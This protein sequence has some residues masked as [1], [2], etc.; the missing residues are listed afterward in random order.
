MTP[1]SHPHL[2]TT[3]ARRLPLLA[4]LI[5]LVA[6]LA[7]GC[8]ASTDGAAAAEGGQ[9][10]R[11]GTAWME[12]S[13]EPPVLNWYLASGGMSI[14]KVLTAPL[15]STWVRLDDRGAWQP[16]LATTV[17]TLDNGGVTQFPEGGMAIS[18][19][20]DPRAVW[21]DG[22]PITCDDLAFTWHTLMDDRWA[23]GSRVGWELVDDVECATPKHVRMMLR[24]AHAPYLANLLNTEPLPAHVL[25]G[26]DFDEVW[27][28]R[29]TVSS[30]PF[31]F[32]RWA[33]GDRLI[34]RRNPRWWNAG[35]EGKPYLDRLVVR[36]VPD[37]NTM[38]LDLR[39]EDADLVGLPPDTNLPAELASI[40]NAQYD[41]RPGAGWENLTF[42]TARFPLDDPRVRRA[43]AFAIDRD[44]L[45]D[46]V[47]ARQ[48]PRL[49]STLLPYQEPYVSPSFSRYHLD[50][51]EVAHRM[52]EAGWE[53][54]GQRDRW[55]D[56][57]GRS[58]KLLLTTTTGSPIRLKTVQIIADQ[59]DVAGFDSEI[60]LLKPEVF[61]AQVVSHG[62]YDLA[63][64]GFTQ[65]VDP[66]QTKLF[67]CSQIA[68]G[69]TW[70]GKNNFKYC[71][72]D[73]DALLAAS[74]RTLDPQRRAEL[75]HELAE[76]L[77]TD[78]PALPLYQ[79]PDTLAWNRRLHGVRPNAMG[80]HLWNVDEWWVSP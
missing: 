2:C 34:L 6:L 68:R 51:R 16:Q 14:T 76:R 45:V 56:P 20:I 13:Q 66:S 74:D 39:M 70:T 80:W 11:G 15:R 3:I 59:L 60:L 69:P 35:P 61:F 21:S 49:D 44:S 55:T 31:V 63:V 1:S 52:Q 33:R 54:H 71:R 37:A 72:R 43:L 73:V 40:P 50:Q 67:A 17:P 46:I 26:A 25:R 65:G 4:A 18:F 28:N 8:G 57:K 10:R 48:V 5:A 41:V 53:R 30:G 58:P 27:N 79:Q 47:L 7:P 12:T 38:K 23:I 24:E 22:V 42:N 77:A 36:F 9:P 29:I 19:A 62:Q 78:V 32:D 75:S 64:Y